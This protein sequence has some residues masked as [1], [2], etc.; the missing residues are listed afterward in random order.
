MSKTVAVIPAR[1]GS[2]SIPNKNIKYFAGKPLIYWTL[3]A[4]ENAQV[5]DEVYVST[6][7]EDIAKTVLSFQF[8]KVRV[9]DR[10]PETATDEASTE[11]VLLEFAERVHF[12]T[13]F[14]I[15]ATSPLLMS[16]DLDRAMFQYLESNCNSMLSVVCQKRFVWT[17][18]G[19]G[20]IPVNYDYNDR[21]RRQEFD[22][23]YVENGAFYI[24]GRDDLIR[25]KS[26]LSGKIA[27][28]EMPAHAY[29]E[30]DEPLD[31]PILETVARRSISLPLSDLTKSIKTLIL[32]VDGVLTDG[33]VFYDRSGESL[34]SF[35]RIDGKGLELLRQSGI[36]VWVISA[37]NSEITR[38]R[39]RKLQIENTFLGIRD[40][41]K[42]AKD[43]AERHKLSPQNIA[44][45]GDDV[46]DLSLLH[47]CGFSAAPRNAVDS[48]KNHVDYVCTRNGGSGCV[49]E[50]VDLIM[51]SKDIK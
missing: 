50:V 34:L 2:K 9:I 7:S 44:V 47:W 39:C 21:P 14:L 12:D 15:Q 45:I 13:L 37:E 26:R 22:G 49:R 35:S 10:S 16:C 32:D 51:S 6:D 36:D 11:S 1:G 41:L 17:V 20:A 28:Y 25:S 5:V 27:L 33:S 19:A 30:L 29:Y 18:S 23:F 31:W 38:Q 24:T 8:S 43:L 48:V 46:Q 40:K 3:Q 4:A 42:L